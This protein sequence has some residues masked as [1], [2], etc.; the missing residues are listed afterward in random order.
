MEANFP[1]MAYLR[2]RGCDGQVV[3]QRLSDART[4]FLIGEVPGVDLAD[5][6]VPEGAEDGGPA[7]HA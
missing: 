5:G 3:S 6:A 7:V 4:E 2:H 1:K